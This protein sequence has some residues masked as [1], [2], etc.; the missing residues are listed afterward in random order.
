MECFPVEQTWDP[1]SADPTDAAFL[2]ELQ[3]FRPEPHSLRAR[4]LEEDI[5]S[6]AYLRFSFNGPDE[7]VPF[8]IFFKILKN[9]PNGTSIRGDLDGRR[10]YVQSSTPVNS[11]VPLS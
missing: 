5:E 2:G 6:R 9:V 4:W 11:L 3:Q 1:K 8:S 7:R 10:Q